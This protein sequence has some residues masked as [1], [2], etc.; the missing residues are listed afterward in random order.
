MNCARFA[1]LG[2]LIARV[3]FGGYMLTHGWA[4]AQMLVNGEGANFGDPIGLGPELSLALAAF[5]EFVCSLLVIVGLATRLA[6]IPIIVT[7]AVAAF[8]AHGSDPWT[9]GGA[10]ELFAAGKTQYPSSKQ[11]ALMFL[12]GFATLLAT[13]PGRLSLDRVFLPKLARRRGSAPAG[14]SPP[15]P[16]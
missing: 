3:G 7:M 2:L 10:H 12:V 1:D 13:G 5:A 15:A 11:P 9:M 6:T 4:K 16:R 14:S 8:V